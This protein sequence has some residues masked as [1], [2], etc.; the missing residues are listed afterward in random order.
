VH[1]CYFFYYIYIPRDP[2]FLLSIQVIQTVIF[3]SKAA[4]TRC[5]VAVVDRHEPIDECNMETEK[6]FGFADGIVSSRI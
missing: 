3:S 1:L 5:V 2:V 6:Q 4:G